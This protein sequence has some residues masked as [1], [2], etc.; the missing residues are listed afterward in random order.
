MRSSK[1]VTLN[2]NLDPAVDE[3]HLQ[4][5]AYTHGGELLAAAPIQ[6]NAA[7]LALD[8]E[9]QERSFELVLGPRVEKGQI[10]P[11]LASLK[12]M[13]APH[14]IVRPG[15]DGLAIDWSGIPFPRWCWCRVRGKLVKRVALP[16][17]LTL[18]RPVCHARVH[19]AEVDRLPLIIHRLPDSDLFRLRDDLLSK[20]QVIK[21]PVLP[22]PIPPRPLQLAVAKRTVDLPDAEVSLFF[23]ALSAPEQR[24]VQRLAQLQDASR[25]RSQ[26][27]DLVHLIPAYL[28]DW[29]YLWSYFRVDELTTLQADANGHFQALIAHDCNDR[30]DLYFWV[31]QFRDGAWHT[32]YRPRVAC[33]TFWN[34]VCGTEVTLDLPGAHTCDEPGYDLPPGVS[35]FVLP[36]AI[37]ASAIWGK[38]A[39]APAAPDGWVRS[40]G[41]IDYHT[42]TALGWLHDAP[43]GGILNFVQDD[44]YF[45]PSAGIRYYRY[46]YRRRSLVANTGA[47]DASWTPINT[48][49]ARGYRMEYSD[50]LPTYESYAVGPV[51]VGGQSNLFEFKPQTPPV[52]P[53]DPASVLVREWT[54]GNLGEVA[55][56][57]NTWLAAPPL[58]ADNATDAA[59]DF[60]IKIEV[61]DASGNQVMP[62]AASFRFLAR[63]ADG[64]STRLAS[65]D[66]VAG[67]AYVLRVHIDNNPVRAEL[68]QPDIDGL[69]ASDNCGFLRYE[70]GDQVHLAYTATH[71][72]QHAVFQFAVK[73]GSNLLDGAC[74]T[75]PYVEVAALT[76]PTS[77]LPYALTTGAYERSFTPAELVGGCVN[78]AFA[79][80]LGVYGKATDGERRLGIDGAQWIA[81]ALAQAPLD[82]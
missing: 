79:A 8:N 74:T 51:T 67:G 39:G 61:F 23:N 59:G 22:K 17:G 24:D 62:G 66:E 15:S 9:Q 43:F 45:I 6:K 53:T 82:A 57:W 55:A 68:P 64:V 75:A 4:A 71:P 44:S 25:L 50:R 26:L 32:V 3:K 58:S 20:L 48:P 31:E 30:P 77:T 56:S 41:Y 14:Q 21:P 5:Y 72:N 54:G 63:N 81:F 42:G 65:G 18:T 29:P 33:A 70:A 13:G 73:R 35:R 1:T 76:A 16:I 12:N 69:A 10:A 46:S 11:T 2:F 40:D 52:R 36:Y 80:S 27:V 28:C 47:A 7:Q 37:G 78:A 60:E 38:P 49:L 34:Y 19:I